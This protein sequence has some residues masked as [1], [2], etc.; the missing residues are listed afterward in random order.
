M[1]RRRGDD[2]KE[3]RPLLSDARREQLSDAREAAVISR[4]RKQLLRLEAEIREVRSKL[5]ADMRRQRAADAKETGE[6]DAEAKTQAKRQRTESKADVR[7]EEEV[8]A[9]PLSAEEA[10]SAAGLALRRCAEARRDEKTNRKAAAKIVD[11]PQP[12]IM[13]RVPS[14][15]RTSARTH[16]RRSNR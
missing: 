13:M 5:E 7:Q 8:V 4:R 1:P 3:S 9:V 15:R 14:S 6:N 2:E 16:R 11:A 12:Q 10:C